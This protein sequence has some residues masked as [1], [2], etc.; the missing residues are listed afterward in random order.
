VGALAGLDQEQGDAVT[1]DISAE[2]GKS[3]T[4]RE[5]LRRKVAESQ[6][7]LARPQLPEREPPEGYRALAMDYPFALVLGGLA[8]GAIAGVLI[9]RSAARK[10]GRA[11]IAAATVAG[12]LGVAYGRQA[13]DAAE[14]LADSGRKRLADLGDSVS[15]GAG[16]YGRKASELAEQVASTAGEVAGKAAETAGVGADTARQAGLK[17]AR[18]VIRLTSQL[19]H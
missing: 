13:R 1:E 2:P 15:D 7:A 10:L 14:E 5:E 3:N 12:E 16:V 6:A 19:R 8:I 4:K 17:I 9:P 18:Q 11:A